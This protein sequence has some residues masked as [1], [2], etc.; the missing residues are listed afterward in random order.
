MK[1]KRRKRYLLVGLGL[2]AIAALSVYAFLTDMQTVG[3]TGAGGD[4]ADVAA[5][6]SPSWT[7]QPAGGQIGSVEVVD[8]FT[9][10]PEADYPGDLQITVYLTNGDELV[11]CYRYLMMEMR[12]FD[13]TPLQVGRTEFVTLI[14]GRATFDISPVW[15]SPYT[16][17]ITGGVYRS[18]KGAPAAGESLSPS[19]YCEVSQR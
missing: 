6:G 16:V 5:V 2:L 9:V 15:T 4:I 8:L 14:N 12:V 17:T 13:N 18:I 7:A 19:F 3:V 11:H 10:T 1:K